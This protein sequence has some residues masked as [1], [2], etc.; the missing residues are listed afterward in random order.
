MSTTSAA[1][2][3]SDGRANNFDFQRFVLATAVVFS[4]SFH[5]LGNRSVPVGVIAVTGF[6]GISGVLVTQSWLARRSLVDFA[7]KRALRIY[8]AFAAVCL[9]D[10]LVV[11][12][13][14]SGEG[15][16]YLGRI[17]PGRVARE[18]VALRHHEIPGLFEDLPVDAVNGSLW[19]IPYEAACYVGLALI[20]TLG[21]L[22]RRGALIALTSVVC[23]VQAALPKLPRLHALAGV[24][25]TV[26]P[27][28]T[29][30]LVG[31]LLRLRGDRVVASTGRTIATVVLL[32][33]STSHRVAFKLVWPVALPYLLL[34]LAHHP[35]APLRGWGRR[36]D[37]SYGLYAFAF[38]V[39]Q[40]LVRFLGTE[41]HPLVLFLAAMLLTMP[42]AVASW[43]LVER[44]FLRL[45][46]WG[47]S[48]RRLDDSVRDTTT[49]TASCA[50][51][52][53]SMA[54]G[55]RTDLG[56]RPAEQP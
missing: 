10:H 25:V 53:G 23:V 14:A 40:L 28:V 42:L 52:G 43:Y 19:T 15:W 16:A 46:T 54:D 36:G 24:Y 44:P 17:D 13:V 11:A 37:F 6:F 8:P 9:F 56:S 34:S 7:R 26:L 39:Q 48:A 12:P 29:A 3:S 35:R 49:R 1:A 55:N 31:V 32:A 2:A 18:I 4:H 21:L 33:V 27:F 22:R 41:L 45:K 38:P 5:V 50:R 30:F 51:H 20:G 47:T